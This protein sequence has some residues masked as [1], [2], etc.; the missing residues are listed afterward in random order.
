VSNQI[1]DFS[2]SSEL[3]L[4][5]NPSENCSNFFH[6]LDINRLGIHKW[7]RSP[8]AYPWLILFFMPYLFVYR[9]LEFAL[10]IVLA[11]VVFPF[12]VLVIGVYSIMNLVDLVFFGPSEVIGNMNEVIAQ[13]RV[14]QLFDIEKGIVG[15]WVNLSFYLTSWVLFLLIKPFEMVEDVREQLWDNY[16]NGKLDLSFIA[17]VFLT[18]IFKPIEVAVSLIAHFVIMPLVVLTLPLSGILLRVYLKRRDFSR[19]QEEARELLSRRQEEARDLLNKDVYESILEKKV[20]LGAWSKEC[21]LSEGDKTNVC[22]TVTKDNLQYIGGDALRAELGTVTQIPCLDLLCGDDDERGI[23][24]VM[25]D[26]GL[27]IVSDESLLALSRVRAEQM[28]V[29]EVGYDDGYDDG[30]YLRYDGTVESVITPGE[31]FSIPQCP[32]IWGLCSAEDGASFSLPVADPITKKR[33]ECDK[34]ILEKLY[35]V[36]LTP[37]KLGLDDDSDALPNG[38]MPCWYVLSEAGV[39]SLSLK[40]KNCTECRPVPSEHFLVH[41]IGG[42]LGFIAGDAPADVSASALDDSVVVSCVDEFVPAGAGARMFSGSRLQA[43]A[44]GT[45]PLAAARTLASTDCRI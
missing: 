23:I 24:H 20:G 21:V 9:L 37:A 27:L 26:E 43:E 8:S 41:L 31:I 2:V 13:G 34:G 6:W 5:L 15:S 33:F 11:A 36:R 40:D 19:R 30:Y 42:Y 25:P 14:P 3:F 18:L 22:V 16:H 4:P 44:A 10:K 29:E 12:A 7:L 39:D 1:N 28:R 17:A 32:S 35:L 38:L 45:G